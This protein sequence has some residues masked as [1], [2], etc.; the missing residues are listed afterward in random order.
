MY[1]DGKMKKWNDIKISLYE[2]SI[3]HLL[4]KKKM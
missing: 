2:F 1:L 4:P 3:M